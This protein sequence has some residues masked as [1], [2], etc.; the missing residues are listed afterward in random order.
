MNNDKTLKIGVIGIYFGKLPNWFPIWL[1][2][3]EYNPTI[4]FLL[5]IDDHVE[6]LPNNVHIF[7][8]SLKEIKQLAEDKLNMKVWLDS[9]YKLCDFKPVWGIILQEYIKEYDYWGHCDFDLLFGDIRKFVNQFKL[10]DYDKFLS[11]GHF[12]LYKN[13]RKC[14]EYYK[15][16]GS[17][18]SYKDAFTKPDACYF[19]EFCNI[20]SI[21]KNNDIP[22]FCD[23]SIFVNISPYRERLQRLDFPNYRN[24][25]FYWENGKVFCSY[26]NDEEEI[27]T[28]EFIYIHIC[29][30]NLEMN[31]INPSDVISLY[32]TP[33]TFEN[34]TINKPPTKEDM[35]H[36]NPY[37]VMVERK[38]NLKSFIINSVNDFRNSTKEK[39]KK[40]K[41][42]FVIYK[43]IRDII[44]H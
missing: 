5:F 40:S 11:L 24:Q 14:Y 1:R 33:H 21:Y 31:I 25:V 6:N 9:P 3:A 12:A 10:S 38:E 13:E 35:E 28:C 43:I 34:K 17:A 15:L 18:V 22:I 26:L 44:H 36:L 30:R 19:D 39:L 29:K 23:E 16:P 42:G 7:N 4:D 2:S 37:N 41:I 20:N 8:S 27:I 32:I